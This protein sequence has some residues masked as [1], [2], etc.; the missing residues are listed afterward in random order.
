MGAVAAGA[1]T[2]CCWSCDQTGALASKIELS[3]IE[4]GRIEP[5][6]IESSKPNPERFVSKFLIPSLNHHLPN[7]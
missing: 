4:P 1:G 6:R 7:K 5:G 2:V 3:K